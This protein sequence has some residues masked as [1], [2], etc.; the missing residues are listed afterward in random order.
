M[1]RHPKWKIEEPT[2]EDLAPQGEER[3]CDG[4]DDEVV[5]VLDFKGEHF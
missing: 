2:E 4:A 1:G 3:D 5:E